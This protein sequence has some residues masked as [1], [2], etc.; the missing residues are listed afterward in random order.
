[1]KAEFDVK[2]TQRA[3]FDFLLSHTY[4]SISGWI[5]VVIGVLVLVAALITIGKVPPASTVLYFFFAVYFLPLQPIMLYFRAARQ[6]KLNP[7]YREV[8]HYAL[9]DDGITSRQ[10]EAEAHIGWDQIVKVRE[11]KC[12]FLLYTGKRYSFVLPKEC[13]GEQLPKVTALVKKHLEPARVH[14]QS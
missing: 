14:I 5:G 13:M 11:T 1:M 6:I 2:M 12:S 7:A 10:K 4:G 9:S 8:F 3:M